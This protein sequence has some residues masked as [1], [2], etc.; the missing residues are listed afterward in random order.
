MTGNWAGPPGGHLPAV[1][2]GLSGP[3]C[4]GWVALRP[5][6]F[7]RSGLSPPGHNL[8]GEGEIEHTLEVGSI[9]V[10]TGFAPFEPAGSRYDSWAALPQV[11]TT[12]TLERLLDP[13]GPPGAGWWPMA[14]PPSP[15]ISPLSCAS[16][17]GRREG[18]RFCSRVCCPTGRLERALELKAR[19]PQA[20]IRIYYRDIRTV[21]KE[22]EALYNRAR[23]AGIGFMRAKVRDIRPG[24]AGS[25]GDRGGPGTGAVGERRPGGPGGPGG[26][27]DA[28]GRR[29]ASG[30]C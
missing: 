22:W 13:Q 4:G 2:H 14:P 21:K 8:G 9:V 18:N 16:A 20:R 19:L 6:R 27:H 7:V 30:R 5:L 24:E 23:E 29:R 3:L 11:I 1:A 28:G 12:V 17:P 10:A 25:L 15:R 26:G